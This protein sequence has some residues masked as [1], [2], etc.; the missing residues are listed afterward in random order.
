MAHATRRKWP[1]KRALVR[2]GKVR[3][4][5][6]TA[7]RR[8]PLLPGVPSII[9]AGLPDFL[10]YN[11]VAA[12]VSAKTP[13]AVVKRLQDLFAQAGNAPD[14][15][16]YYTR[17]SAELIL[18]SRVEMRQFQRMRGNDSAIKRRARAPMRGPGT[19]TDGVDG[20]R[21]LAIASYIPV[22]SSMT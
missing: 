2:G 14:V 22:T 6:F 15:R 9:E 1:R 7:P 18:S 17:L 21:Y 11:W 5:A 10:P 20:S 3:A 4:L 16:D 19:A 12:A 13:P 8:S